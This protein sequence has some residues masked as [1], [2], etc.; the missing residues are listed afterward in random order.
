ASAPTEAARERGRERR[1]RRGGRDV[2]EVLLHLG[3]GDEPADQQDEPA[4]YRRGPVGQ[5]ARCPGGELL[6]QV[7]AERVVIQ[8]DVTHSAGPRSDA[9]MPP[10][11]PGSCRR[12]ARSRP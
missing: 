4:E 12:T 5:P 8:G 1:R 2:P 7:V 6:G 9:G 3:T 10:G 11:W